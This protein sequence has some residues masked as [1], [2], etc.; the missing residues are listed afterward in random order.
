MRWQY[1]GTILTGVAAL[2]TAGVGLY[3]KL[4]TVNVELNKVLYKK[5]IAV[6]KEY[7]L[8]DDK[9]GWTYLRESPNTSSPILA[10]LLNNTNLEIVDKSGNWFKVLTESGREGYIFKDRAILIPY[11]K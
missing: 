8:V 10:K 6:K 5:N 11:E 2:I 4:H 7:C 9:D 1:L 3:D